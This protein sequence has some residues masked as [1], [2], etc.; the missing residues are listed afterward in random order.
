[1]HE[2]FEPVR[3]KIN[4]VLTQIS[5]FEL[6]INNFKNKNLIRIDC[7]LNERRLG[8]KLIQRS[9]PES[10]PTIE[11]NAQ[12]GFRYN[13]IADTGD[14]LYDELQEIYE[15]YYYSYY[16]SDFRP[17]KKTREDFLKKSEIYNSFRFEDLKDYG[18]KDILMKFYDRSKTYNADEYIVL[19]ETMSDHRSLPEK[20]RQALYAGIKEAIIKHGGQHTVDYI[21]QL[22][23]GKK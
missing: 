10:I 5:E 4:R 14:K 13:A 6:S 17:V 15:E 19:L 3:S 9:M 2:I 21:F 18:F 7:I 8:Y 20:N 1:M 16:T 11:W 23:M 12:F 22:Y